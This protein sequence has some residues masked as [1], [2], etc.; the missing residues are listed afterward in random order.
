M[1]PSHSEGRPVHPARERVSP[2]WV[3][4][5]TNLEFF[6][7]IH[8]PYLI[9]DHL[10]NNITSNKFCKDVWI[11]LFQ[12]T[13]VG[14][15]GIVVI[16]SLILLSQHLCFKLYTQIT[17]SLS[18]HHRFASDVAYLDRLDAKNLE[19]CFPS[20]RLHWSR[21]ISLFGQES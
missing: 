8:R 17:L 6:I 18:S 21:D 14:S 20:H 13:F 11:V 4:V 5:E 15:I 2:K 10:T 12:F 19:S 16:S 9:S 3:W 1:N 7:T